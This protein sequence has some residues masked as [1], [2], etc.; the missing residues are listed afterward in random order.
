MPS[1]IKG[2]WQAQKDR[3][4]NVEDVGMTSEGMKEEEEQPTMHSTTRITLKNMDELSF[5]L[6]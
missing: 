3:G 5:M 6:E 2:I 1:I 4:M